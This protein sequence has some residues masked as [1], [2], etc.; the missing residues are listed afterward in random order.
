MMNTLVVMWCRA[1]RYSTKYSRMKKSGHAQLDP[2]SV[3]HNCKHDSKD[4]RRRRRT[5]TA[6]RL[7]TAPKRKPANGTFI[8]LDVITT[9]IESAHSHLDCSNRKIEAAFSL[10]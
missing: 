8:I 9:T 4:S 7:T 5:P 6:S 1:Y 2:S 10:L 3:H